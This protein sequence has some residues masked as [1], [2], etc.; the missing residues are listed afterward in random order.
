[1]PAEAQAVAKAAV[2]HQKLDPPESTSKAVYI[3][4]ILDQHR[5]GVEALIGI[6]TVLLE[7]KAKLEHG[8]FT[9]MVEN[10]LPFGPRQAQYLMAIAGHP[11]LANPKH[12][13]LL[14]AAQGTLYALSR[15]PA[16]DLEK[17]IDKGLI[18]PEIQRAEIDIVRGR[19]PAPAPKRPTP[20]PTPSSSAD[21]SKIAK[22]APTNPHLFKHLKR[23]KTAED[24]AGMASRIADT[25]QVNADLLAEVPA[26]V[27]ASVQASEWVASLSKSR[28]EITRFISA[29]ERRPEDH[30]V[31]NDVVTT[32][33]ALINAVIRGSYSRDVYLKASKVRKALAAS[34]ASRADV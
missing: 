24:W 12:T 5:K 25:I 26:D 8:T 20:A 18:R 10:D 34:P 9:D 17:A 33:N 4:V 31:S 21:E 2:T 22:S 3:K 16:S 30:I 6:G 14:P 13:S 32:V 15:I 23:E 7:A 11:V 28:T 19:I 1:M 29:C 27:R